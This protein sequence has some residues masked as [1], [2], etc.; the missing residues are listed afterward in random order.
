M[1][2]NPGMVAGW[3]WLLK[4]A[5]IAVSGVPYTLHCELSSAPGMCL[6]DCC[7][8]P[9]WCVLLCSQDDGR[10][11]VYGP[12]CSALAVTPSSMAALTNPPCFTSPQGMV[13]PL[14]KQ[15]SGMNT[16]RVCCLS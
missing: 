13:W 3:F 6:V 12:S 10:F 8:P 9:A 4:G 1:T 7:A 16:A 5:C 2:P 14:R 11:V 15:Q